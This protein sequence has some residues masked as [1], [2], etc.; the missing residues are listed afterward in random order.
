[1]FN[2]SY[3]VWCPPIVVGERKT[4]TVIL[5]Y[6]DFNA[7]RIE[8]IKSLSSV[9]WEFDVRLDRRPIT[10][11]PLNMLQVTSVLRKYMNKQDVVQWYQEDERWI[12]QLASGDRFFTPEISD[13]CKC[14][15]RM[16]RLVLVG[17]SHLRYVFDYVA[18]QCYPQRTPLSMNGSR[19]IENLVYLYAYNEH[20]LYKATR[21]GFLGITLGEDD[22][23]ITQW[24]SHSLANNGLRYT[25]ETALQ[26]YVD[27]TVAVRKMTRVPASRFIVVIQP[28]FSYHLTGRR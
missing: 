23:I 4:I 19:V 22:V 12:V 1:M 7:F 2:G 24:G 16:H 27:T 9:I 18:E 26:K 14:V 5:Q 17:A 10:P 15:K 11:K 21:K 13:M 6:V 8:R 28:P 3:F 20:Q 25:L